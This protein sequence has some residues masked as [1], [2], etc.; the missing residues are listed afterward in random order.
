MIDTGLAYLAVPVDGVL[1]HTLVSHVVE[2]LIDELREDSFKVL[3]TSGSR[4][5]VVGGGGGSGH[6]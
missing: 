1:G 3:T 2:Q 4:S 6:D 5:V